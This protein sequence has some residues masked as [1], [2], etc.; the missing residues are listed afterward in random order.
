MVFANMKSR[1]I[2]FPFFLAASVLV[3][4]GCT[5]K[6]ATDNQPSLPNRNIQSIS[7]DIQS[8]LRI[9]LETRVRVQRANVGLSL[10]MPQ[11]WTNSEIDK[12]NSGITFAVAERT[13]FLLIFS[14]FHSASFI[15]VVDD[16]VD[17][18]KDMRMYISAQYFLDT[19]KTLT[20]WYDE[21]RKELVAMFGNPVEEQ[22]MVTNG[23]SA[24]TII[25][26]YADPAD[27]LKDI[28]RYY[29]YRYFYLSH[30]GKVYEV[31]VDSRSELYNYLLPTVEDILRSVRLP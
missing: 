17:L 10:L 31:K 20:K 9:P 18:A 24:K 28:K 11:A 13:P 1:T 8:P 21:H 27:E 5:K 26:R 29:T 7:E 22:N 6:F 16:K 19:E 2:I 3:V 23:L 14:P 4:S 30:Q 15:Q 25:F 12:S